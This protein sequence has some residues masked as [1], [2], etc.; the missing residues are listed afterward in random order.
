[1]VSEVKKV[2][3]C[4][5]LLNKPQFYLISILKFLMYQIIYYALMRKTFFLNSSHVSQPTI[6]KY[7]GYYHT[8]MVLAHSGELLIEICPFVI[9]KLLESNKMKESNDI[10]PD[11]RCTFLGTKQLLLW[12]QRNLFYGPIGSYSVHL[13]IEIIRS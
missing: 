3:I 2:P 10:L 9:Y 1:M 13:V 8:T 12:V 6:W 4:F 7:S 11:A 5:N